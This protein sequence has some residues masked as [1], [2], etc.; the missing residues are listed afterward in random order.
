MSFNALSIGRKIGLAFSALLVISLAMLFT[1]YTSLAKIKEQDGWTTHTYEVLDHANVLL[2]AVV[3]QETGVRGFLIGG[4][5]N[6][7]APFENGKTVY[8]DE[9][10]ALKELTSDNP[11]QQERLQSLYEAEEKWRTTIAEREIALMKNPLTHE[12]ARQIEASGAGKALMDNI[13][14]IH[15]EFVEAEASLLDD[16]ALAKEEATSLAYQVIIGG[17]VLLFALATGIG[18]SL[19]RSIA[20]SMADMT[21]IT[22]ALSKGDTSMDVPHKQR[23]D[24]I[25]AMARAI[26]DVV[27]NN[28]ALARTAAKIAEGDLRV[29][30]EPR[31]EVDTLGKAIQTMLVQ[32]RRTITQTRRSVDLVNVRAGSMSATSEQ[33]SAGSASQAAAAEEASAAIEQMTANISQTADNASQTEKIATQSAADAKKSGEA[34]DRAVS[35]MKTIA[36]KINIIQE[37]ARQT[38]LLALNAA[39]EAARAGS[40]G[41]GFAVVASEVRKLAERS[42]AAAA[43]ISQLSGETVEV[44]GEAGRMLETLVP[45]IQRTADLVQEI[46]AATREQNVGAEQINQ[47]IR[48]LDK[49]I[50]QNASA[51]DMSAETSKE[52]ADDAAKLADVISYF[53]IVQTR[54]AGNEAKPRSQPQETRA[55]V[56]A[57]GTAAK[58][59]AKSSGGGL[60]LDLDDQDPL[61]AEF[62]RYAS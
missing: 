8:Q 24:E 2:S 19:S 44:S 21:K 9:I 29:E 51:A 1:V 20:H 22:T 26:D 52:L 28:R 16:R 5:D 57:T 11:A 37:I 31:S 6:F 40:H 46:S 56:A 62:Q 43:E 4:T 33:L 45:N 38:D 18:V 27:T 12:E 49:V 10:K 55:K 36:S 3:N 30:M 53:Q 58:S 54:E 47:A 34:V 60:K 50:Q 25:G 13:R 35:A 7:L 23:G 42:Q 61:D 39:V 17:T 14:A 15:A 59:G 32:L 41:K 48:E